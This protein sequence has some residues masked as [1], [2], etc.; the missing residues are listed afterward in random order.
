[1]AIHPKEGGSFLNYVHLVCLLYFRML[2]DC[3]PLGTPEWFYKLHH[4][5]LGH[6]GA[7]FLTPFCH[8]ALKDAR[9]DLMYWPFLPSI[10]SSL[11]SI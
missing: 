5:F 7:S 4:E 3:H 1:M 8:L 10:A 6:W 2:S 11:T 9:L